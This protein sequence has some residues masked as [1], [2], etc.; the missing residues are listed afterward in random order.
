MIFIPLFMITLVHY[1]LCFPFVTSR[2]TK[3]CSISNEFM[4]IDQDLDL[5]QGSNPDLTKR[6]DFGYIYTLNSSTISLSADIDLGSKLVTQEI[7]SSSA[8]AILSHISYSETNS[9]LLLQG[10]ISP[11]NRFKIQQLDNVVR[12]ELRTYSYDEKNHQWFSKFFSD[13]R[14]TGRIQRTNTDQ[15]QQDSSQQ[16]VLELTPY[17][18]PNEHLQIVSSASGE[19][20][21]IDW[22]SSCNFS[23]QKRSEQ[24]IQEIMDSAILL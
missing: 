24:S 8:V 18:A 12:L 2:N 20:Q 13:T 15:T 11:M 23:P 16:L 5:E 7:L 9:T 3:N 4:Q 1:T 10:W 19:G 14:I 22:N 17:D 21:W 6:S